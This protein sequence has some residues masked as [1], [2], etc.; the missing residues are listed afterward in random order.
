[1]QN[2]TTART[3][4]TQARFDPDNPDHYLNRISA[5][6][7]QSIFKI[8]MQ[9]GPGLL[10]KTY[11]ECLFYDL[12]ENQNLKVE[13]QKCL[14]LTFEKLT[15][16]NAYIVDLLVKDEIIVELKACEKVLPVHKAQLLTYMKIHQSRLGYLVNFNEKLIKNGIH[17]FVL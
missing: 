11:E 17:R 5:K 13:R 1:M 12:T 3:D 2:L 6:I 8:H 16:P 14:P 10:E 7:R 9:F 4:E 15:I